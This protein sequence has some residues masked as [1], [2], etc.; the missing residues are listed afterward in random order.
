MKTH[1]SVGFLCREAQG[2]NISGHAENHKHGH[3]KICHGVFYAFCGV[4]LA[5]N[6]KQDKGAKGRHP[7]RNK[8]EYGR[9]IEKGGFKIEA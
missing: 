6:F 7:K 1:L 5:I 9:V 4:L 8:A 2:K 3:G